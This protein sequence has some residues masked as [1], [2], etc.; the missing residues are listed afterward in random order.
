MI[1]YNVLNHAGLT[2]ISGINLFQ[3]RYVLVYTS[4]ALAA[5]GL[6]IFA[7]VF[8]PHIAISVVLAM[9]VSLALLRINRSA[10]DIEN[11]FPEILSLP[12]IRPILGIARRPL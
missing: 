3:R 6:L 12:F 4:I 2:L 5:G 7:R 10:M 8:H 1:L 11:M 9:M